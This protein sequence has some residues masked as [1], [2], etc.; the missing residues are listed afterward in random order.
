MLWCALIGGF[1]FGFLVGIFAY[2]AAELAELRAL[3]RES[4]KQQKEFAAFVF[5][6]AERVGA[7][8]SEGGAK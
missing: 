1:G 5:E 8:R 7:I 3:K 2:S 6:V 4:D